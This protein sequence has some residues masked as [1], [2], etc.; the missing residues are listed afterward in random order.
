MHLRK[1]TRQQYVVIDGR[2]LEG[3]D[4]LKWYNRSVFKRDRRIVGKR[5]SV[6]KGKHDGEIAYILGAL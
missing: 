1:V 2:P 5:I 6:R 4:N 3:Y